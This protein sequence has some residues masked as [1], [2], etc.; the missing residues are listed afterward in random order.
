MLEGQDEGPRL[1]G[2]VSR[3]FGSQHGHFAV[4][5]M[6]VFALMAIVLA[7]SWARHS[8]V[9][10]WGFHSAAQLLERARPSSAAPPYTAWR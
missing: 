2:R 7:Q 5:A 8:P 6:V 3:W 9:T 10:K 1:Y 4:D